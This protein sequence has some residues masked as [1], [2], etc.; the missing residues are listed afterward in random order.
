MWNCQNTLQETV[1]VFSFCFSNTILYNRSV[2][3]EMLV[4]FR[5]LTI[6]GQLLIEIQN[7]TTVLSTTSVLLIYKAKTRRIVD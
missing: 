6:V 5:N 3:T 7:M 4:L 2:D 1:K